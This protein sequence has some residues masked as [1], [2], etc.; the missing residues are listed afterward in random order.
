MTHSGIRV[1]AEAPWFIQTPLTAPL[2][3]REVLRAVSTFEAQE[4]AAA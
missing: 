1:N 3:A 2:L 4:R